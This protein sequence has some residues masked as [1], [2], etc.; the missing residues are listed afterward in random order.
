[1]TFDTKDKKE[2]EDDE[3]TRTTKKLKN[4]CSRNRFPVIFNI[5]NAPNSS[6]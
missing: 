1:M 6:K 3:K 5:V 2:E 4:K